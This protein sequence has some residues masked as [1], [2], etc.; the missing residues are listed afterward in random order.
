MGS[1]K[2]WWTLNL[3]LQSPIYIGKN[4]IAYLEAFANLIKF[5]V[6]KYTK[7]QDLRCYH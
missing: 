3:I 1:I 5:E 7:F 2:R 4:K 6:Y